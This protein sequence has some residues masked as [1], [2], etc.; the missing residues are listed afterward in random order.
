M[1]KNKQPRRTKDDEH[2]PNYIDPNLLQNLKLA[3]LSTIANVP[4]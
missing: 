4:K 3:I 2:L 1:K